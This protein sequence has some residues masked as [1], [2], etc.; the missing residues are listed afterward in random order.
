MSAEPAGDG[1]RVL[2]VQLYLRRAQ[3]YR[4]HP[5]A[6]GQGAPFLSVIVPLGAET[7]VSRTC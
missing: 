4:V 6:H 3:V 1:L 2:V 7:V 5:R